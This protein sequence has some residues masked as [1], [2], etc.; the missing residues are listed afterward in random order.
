MWEQRQTFGVPSTHSK[1]ENQK[2]ASAAVSLTAEWS[3][4]VFGSEEDP[5][6]ANESVISERAKVGLQAQRLVGR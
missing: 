2:V 1:T 5:G 6:L 3:S 4:S